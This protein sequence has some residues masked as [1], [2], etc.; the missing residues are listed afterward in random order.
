MQRLSFLFVVLL[1][2][3]NAHAQD[4]G[5]NVHFHGFADNRE[6][7]KSNRYSQSILGVRIA[8]EIMLSLDSVHYLHSGVN[9]LHEFGSTAYDAKNMSPTIYYQYKQRGFDFYIGMFPRRDLLAGY[10]RA[11]L[12]DTLNYYRPNIEGMLWRYENRVFHQQL[13]I[14]WTSRQTEEHRE[15][16]MVGLSGR[17]NM[18]LWYLSHNVML[19][20]NA[21]RMNNTDPNELPV[22]DNGAA[23]V[24][25]GIDLSGSV[26]DSL[27]ISG[28]GIVAYDRLR[29][30]YDWR[31]PAGVMVDGY[32][33]YKKIFVANTLYAG[34]SL[35]IAY[36]DRFYTAD[37]YD[38]L[39]LGW[40]PL[41]YKGL[42]GKFTLSFHFT[43][44]AIDNQQQFTL[45][46]QLGR[47]YS[48]GRQ[49]R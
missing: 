6:Y 33:E 5:W 20:H 18:G 1:S 13:W 26:L 31:T 15:Q 38:R 27:D 47:L 36:G 39:E 41:Q 9:F 30:V 29:G 16:F 46:Y 49:Q 34:E 44:G 7:A 3:V 48:H 17:V 24:K 21:G 43:P 37:F 19:W 11:I 42:E 8:P 23:L 32:A 2:V 4:I 12:I 40:K 45:Q 10:H 25:I 35:D 22:R 14:D 28:G